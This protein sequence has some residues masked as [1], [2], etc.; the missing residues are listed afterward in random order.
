MKLSMAVAR[1]AIQAFAP[2]VFTLALGAC[3]GGGGG[4]APAPTP[5]T[6]TPSTYTIGGV[7]SGLAQGETVRVL[8]DGADGQTV[9]A[10]GSF[11][12]P[13]ALPPGTSYSAALGPSPD[14]KAC[15]MSNSSGS[16]A[17]ANVTNITVDC[18]REINWVTNGE[19]RTTALSADGKT[20]FIGGEF[21]R[22][23]RRSGSFVPL[24]ASSGAV[25]PH[26]IVNGHV[27]V[28]LSDGN[29]GWFIGGNFSSVGGVAR[30]YLAKLR[31][32]GTLDTTFKGQ[33]NSAVH[34]LALI[35]STLYIGG[36]FS[37]VNNQLAPYLT[38]LD[39]STGGTR[40]WLTTVNGPVR[41]LA[42]LGNTV[43]IGGN[44]GLVNGVNR[45]NLAAVDGT[46]GAVT[47]WAPEPSYGLNI[48]DIQRVVATDSTIYVAGAFSSIGGKDRASLAALD[49][50]SGSALAWDAALSSPN[51]VHV[52]DIV[53]DGTAIYI[54]G[55]FTTAG[56]ATRASVAVVDAV[57]GAALPWSLDLTLTKYEAPL[58]SALA[59]TSDSVFLSGQFVLPNA[60]SAQRLAMVD[61]K[62]GA[63]RGGVDSEG[64]TVQ[65]LTTVGN[66]VWASGKMNLLNGQVRPGLAAIDTATG[67]LTAWNPQPVFAADNP[68]ISATTAALAVDGANVYVA[69]SFTAIGGVTR[70]GFAKVDA[71]SG[72]VLPWSPA[73]SGGVS[74]LHISNGTLYVGGVELDSVNGQPR[75]NLVAFDTSSGALKPWAPDAT[76]ATINAIYES[77]STVYV[78]GEF[79]TIGGQKR[80]S[81]AAFDSTS[82][83]LLPWDPGVTWRVKV[84]IIN[85]MTVLGNSLYF[86]GY[87]DGVGGQSRWDSAAVDKN[88]GLVQPWAANIVLGFGPRVIVG[89][90]DI[91]Y[92]ASY[93]AVPESVGVLSI[94]TTGEMGP[95]EVM[96]DNGHVNSISLSETQIFLGGS[97]ED[98]RLKRGG[99]ADD[100]RLKYHPSLTVVPR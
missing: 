100:I 69:G 24:D 32:D 4:A 34:A 77:G 80:T 53:V 62:T 61:K 7:V 3:G 90:G 10:N 31:S 35:G 17:S 20:L 84:P 98:I 64:A 96:L 8:N 41:H 38:A 68:S 59:V 22:V 28:Q 11:V 52:Y 1:R 26:V 44:F 78:G 55:K 93:E 76:S 67:A 33:P 73:I 25:K 30:H 42:S 82:G 48:P 87:F 58:V 14:G 6:P 72:E 47:A 54:G 57:T 92:I 88:T 89:K 50:A 43:Y 29:G 21:S 27:T 81:L 12:F 75:K 15:S 9:S 85:S 49:A 91:L 86:V 16:V 45:R 23:G 5:P 2:I 40:A 51:G 56:D 94:R 46:T 79:S 13:T 66:T 74:V 83:A 95:L 65:R 18:S 97:F 19:V 37:T 99:L 39:A 70:N 60:Q 71:S 63:P 36:G